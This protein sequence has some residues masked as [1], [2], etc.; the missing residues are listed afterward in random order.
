MY[1]VYGG[2]WTSPDTGPWPRTEFDGKEEQPSSPLASQIRLVKKKRGQRQGHDHG[3]QPTEQYRH[4]E[5][6]TTGI[7]AA[8]HDRT[9]EQHRLG[10]HHFPSN[11]NAIPPDF[12]SPSQNKGASC[13]YPTDRYDDWGEGEADNDGESSPLARYCYRKRRA[14]SGLNAWGGKGSGKALQLGKDATKGGIWAEGKGNG[15]KHFPDETY[16][17]FQTT[18]Q[19]GK[20][21]KKGR[22][23]AKGKGNGSKQF[24]D[25]AYHHFQTAQHAMRYSNFRDTNIRRSHHSDRPHSEDAGQKSVNRWNYGD[26]Y[27]DGGWVP[28]EQ[29]S[30]EYDEWRDLTSYS[31]Q[32]DAD[33][34]PATNAPPQ[35]WNNEQSGRAHTMC[36]YYQY[37]GRQPEFQATNHPYT[38]WEAPWYAVEER[39]VPQYRHSKEYDSSF[40][41]RNEQCDWSPD[42]SHPT[43]NI[44]H[45][46]D[47]RR[48]QYKGGKGSKGQHCGFSAEAVQA[49]PPQDLNLGDEYAE[50]RI[51]YTRE[52]SLLHSQSNELEDNINSHYF[53]NEYDRRG[54]HYAPACEGNDMYCQDHQPI[55]M[56]RPRTPLDDPSCASGD[57]YGRDAR[58][59]SHESLHWSPCGPSVPRPGNMLPHHPQ[60]PVESDWGGRSAQSDDSPMSKALRT[61]EMKKWM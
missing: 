33:Y 12:Y 11:Q 6:P 31:L 56:H 55:A 8:R 2:S 49:R 27:S 24:P 51:P 5:D 17:H 52:M 48:P 22:I 35:H 39:G 1:D 9:N 53:R 59:P 38:S 23:W 13:D 61:R 19:L 60:S 45:M 29:M 37:K 32:Y 57:C 50:H 28:A 54:C 40:A 15:S 3:G 36:D 43:S 47:E 42:Y 10:A 30:Q 44:R 18:H 4:F 46:D 21:A 34:L 58:Y 14:H 7:Y 26:Q 25:E 41:Y 20:D 16:H